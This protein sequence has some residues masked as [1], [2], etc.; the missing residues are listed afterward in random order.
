MKIRKWITLIIIGGL[1]ALTACTPKSGDIAETIPTTTPSAGTP[2]A[3]DS[4]L[5]LRITQLESFLERSTPE[6]V[7]DLWGRAVCA[8][9]GAVQYAL[10]DDALRAKNYARFNSMNWQIGTT[11]FS[12]DVYAA[13]KPTAGTEGKMLVAVSIWQETGAAP[14]E[15]MTILVMTHKDGGWYITAEEEPQ[16]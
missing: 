3:Q 6:S 5:E 9:N 10:Y 14:Y 4:A 12:G 7:A 2:Q 1:L 8:R 11:G 13:N 15:E 16:P